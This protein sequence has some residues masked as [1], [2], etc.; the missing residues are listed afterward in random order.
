[1]IVK[2]RIVFKKFSG[3][4]VMDRILAGKSAMM[5]YSKL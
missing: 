1:M 4:E 3:L 2:L 5:N